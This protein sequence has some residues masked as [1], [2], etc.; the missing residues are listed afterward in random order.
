LALLHDRGNTPHLRLS[1]KIRLRCP[2]ITTPA[3]AQTRPETP[4]GPGAFYLA[5]ILFTA[6][7]SSSSVT[8]HSSLQPPSDSRDGSTHGAVMPL[9]V[10]KRD[11]RMRSLCGESMDSVKGGAHCFNFPITILYGRPHG[12]SFIESKS[13]CQA[14]AFAMP[15]RRR[16]LVFASSLVLVAASTSVRETDPRRRPRRQCL[17]RLRAS[18]AA[19]RGP[20]IS[21][22]HQYIARRVRGTTLGIA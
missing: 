9:S 10:G 14:T 20:A 7:R 13:S 1:L 19:R 18:L 3:V 22:L 17:S 12:S 15:I 16:R 21:G 2:A 5:R 11:A 6:S 4:L 8:P